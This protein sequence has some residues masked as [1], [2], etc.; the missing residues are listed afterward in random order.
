MMIVATRKKVANK[1]ALVVLAGKDW[2]QQDDKLSAI[3]QHLN[4]VPR[5]LKDG[6]LSLDEMQAIFYFLT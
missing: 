6:A 4:N 2:Q 5:Q 3:K 1:Q